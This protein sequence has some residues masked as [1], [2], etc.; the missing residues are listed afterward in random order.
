MTI[1]APQIGG[2]ATPML[3][4]A[5]GGAGG[6]A[7]APASGFADMLKGKLQQVGDLQEVG[8][9]ASQQMATGKVDDVARALMQVEQAN[10]SLQLTTQLRNKVVEAYQEILRMQV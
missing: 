8:A 5:S 9:Q 3:D 6:A 4:A 1:P 10:I 2:L 7:G